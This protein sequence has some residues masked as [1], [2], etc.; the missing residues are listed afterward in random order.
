MKGKRL[1]GALVVGLSLA[2]MGVLGYRWVEFRLS[3]AITNA[4]FVESD[5]FVKVSYDRLGG[6]IVK[7]FKEEGERVKKGEPLAK[8]DD[9]SVKLKLES[10]RLE[11]ERLKKEEKALRVKRDSLR[12][13]LLKRK[14][15]LSFKEEEISQNLGALEAQIRQLQ[16]DRDRFKRLY[17]KGVVP[18]RKYED[19]QTKLE[20]LQKKAAALEATLKALKKEKEVIEV[21]IA[22]LKELDLK[23]QALKESIK[24]LEKRVKDVENLLEDTVLRSPINGY[25]VKRFVSEGETVRQGQAIYALYDPEDVYILVLLEETKLEGIRVGSKAYIKIDAFPNVKFEGVVKEIG[26]AAAAKFALIP[27]DVTAGE[28]TKVAQRIPVKI[29]LTKGDKRL[30]RVGMGGEVAIEKW[31][32]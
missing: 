31:R 24:S 27:R 5:T 10:L 22:S 3:H 6:K 25:V 20:A 28:F 17:E 29:E 8:L 15:V 32:R 4:V 11:L 26:R 16:R 19:I 21:K 9:R 2:V 13:E 7:L 12:K 23:V 18:A 14:E 30:L 1:I